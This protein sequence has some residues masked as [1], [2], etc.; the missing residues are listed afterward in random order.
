MVDTSSY[1]KYLLSYLCLF[2]AHSVSPSLS[3]ENLAGRRV[4]SSHLLQPYR[5][6][7]DAKKSD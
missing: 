5:P 6:N 3:A 7:G 1:Q 4:R 2:S